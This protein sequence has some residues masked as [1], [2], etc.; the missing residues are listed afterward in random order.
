MD[1][2]ALI[3]ELGAV[4]TRD[5]ALAKAGWSHLVLVSCIEDGTPDLTGFCYL[6]GQKP[7]PVSPRDY[8]VFDVLQG[9]RDAMAEHDGKNPWLACLVRI[10]K[11]SGKIDVDFEY[12]DASR[13]SVTPSNVEQRA[14]EFAPQP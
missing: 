14:R 13:W 6:P 5:A 4:V 2:D 1:R 12:A 3:H 10:D 11:A 8:S 9:L 7:V